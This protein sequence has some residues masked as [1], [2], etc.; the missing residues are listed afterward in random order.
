MTAPVLLWF[1]ND[2]RL[3]DQAAVHAAAATGRPLVPIYVHDDTERLPLGGAARWWLHHSLASL[4]ESLTA[5]GTRLTLRRGDP[6]RVIG[7]LAELVGADSVFAG[8]VPDPASRAAD[9]A[10]AARLSARG[11]AF[12]RALTATLYRPDAVTTKAGGPFGVYTPFARACRALPPPRDPLPAP[13]SLIAGPAVPSDRLDDWS[14]LPTRPDWAGGLRATWTPGE[15]G[16]RARLRAFLAD[17]IG[18]Y[19]ARRDVPGDAGTSMLSPHLHF[20]EISAN[21]VYHAADACHPGD[22]PARFMGELLWRE[23]SYHLLWHNPT[24]AEAPLRP[25]FANMPWR[26]DQAGLEA[27][28]HGRTGVPIVDAGMRQLW[29]T[30]WMHN[31][32]RMIAASFLT[33]HLL[34]D[35][36][37]G[38][39]W[40]WDTLVDA[41]LANNAASWQW[42]AG[43][44]I[45][46]APFFRIFNPVTQGRKFDPD[47][48]YIRRYVP[49]L[50]SL[51]PKQIHAP[52]EF[53]Q[54]RPIVD[55]AEG[56]E[57]ALAAF[58]RSRR[59]PSLS[60]DANRPD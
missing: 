6:A 24:L 56:R 32:V 52:W 25:V 19:A 5:R 58:A 3:S 14:L 16:A 43:C 18:R 26:D 57:R 30:G 54:A 7:D 21:Q 15:R 51:D 2:L 46:A 1:R 33:K 55:L 23:F 38:Q 39:A 59:G 31:R 36:R 44:G 40:F 37:L 8:V 9:R 53:G 34:I 29:L 17:A 50:A 42:V 41:D 27:W 20:G 48:A 60:Q 13:T 10:L 47:G 49:E 35:W 12:R 4:A 22:G 28:R 11:I 45:D